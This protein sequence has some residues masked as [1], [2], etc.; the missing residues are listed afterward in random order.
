MALSGPW[1]KASWIASETSTAPIGTQPE[2]MPLATVIMSGVT[3]KR[4]AA[5]GSPTRPKP[6]ITSSN[7][8]RMPCRSQISRSRCR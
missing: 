2:V 6:V 8:S 3:P 1:V 4:C 7:T 5:N